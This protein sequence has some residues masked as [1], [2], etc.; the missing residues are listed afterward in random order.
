MS[1]RKVVPDINLKVIHKYANFLQACGI[2]G[3]LSK[4][5]SAFSNKNLVLLILVNDIA[6]EGMSLTI[7]ERMDLLD[8]WSETCEKTNQFLM[9]QIGGA[10]LKDVIE[11][12]IILRVF[13]CVS[14]AVRTVIYFFQL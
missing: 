3:V 9:V 2:K 5:R 12:V 11:L 1:F 7:R 14:Y 4:L 13:V 6:G 8:T 10:P